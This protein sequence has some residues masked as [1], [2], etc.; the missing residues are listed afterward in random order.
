MEEKKLCV[1][2]EHENGGKASRQSKHARFGGDEEDDGS[3]GR[4]LCEVPTLAQAAAGFGL[5]KSQGLD[6]LSRVRSWHGSVP[7]GTLSKLAKI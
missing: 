5:K 3:G 6:P 7:R 1:G 2:K 4:V